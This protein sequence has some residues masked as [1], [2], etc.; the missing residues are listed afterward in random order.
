MLKPSNVGLE[1]EAQMARGWEGSLNGTSGKKGRNGSQ[2]QYPPPIK[3]IHLHECDKFSV[4]ILMSQFTCYSIWMEYGVLD[5]ERLDFFAD[6]NLL[7]ASWF[8]YSAS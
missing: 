7:Y 5:P 3:Y 4:S 2:Q 1:Q 8:D 6:W